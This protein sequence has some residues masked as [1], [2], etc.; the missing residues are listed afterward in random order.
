MLTAGDEAPRPLG[1][2]TRQLDAHETFIP[3][4]TRTR[5]DGAQRIIDISL[6]PIDI[7]VTPCACNG[8]MVF[9]SGDAGR[10]F[11]PI[12]RGWLGP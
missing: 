10:L 1:E 11:T 5:A 6:N 8:M 4:L 9:P 2:W 12:M 7:T 3:E